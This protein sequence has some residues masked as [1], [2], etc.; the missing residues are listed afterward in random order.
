MKDR[1]RKVERTNAESAIGRVRSLR[2]DGRLVVIDGGMGSELEARG[3]T[4]DHDAWSGLVNLND[5]ALVRRVHEDY[6]RVGA[7]VLITN[8]FM[9][10]TGPM[11][12]AGFGARFGEA[13]RNAVTAARDAAA[14]SDRAVL[15]AGSVSVTELGAPE[16]G[17][18]SGAQQRGRLRDG[19]V[20][21]VDLLAGEGVDLIALEMVDRALRAQ[22]LTPS[23]GPQRT[24]RAVHPVGSTWTASL[25]PQAAQK[26]GGSVAARRRR[27]RS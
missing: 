25:R 4:M 27:Q 10:G 9:A 22:P 21:Q 18:A 1:R 8:T 3:A 5:P 19:Y 13:N 23:R 2:R 7:D 15:I 26:R 16:V 12:R 6:V 11:A 20:R 14:Q 17:G 24:H